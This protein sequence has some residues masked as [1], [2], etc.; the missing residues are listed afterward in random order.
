VAAGGASVVVSTIAGKRFSIPSI[1]H[2]KIPIQE[3]NV[4]EGILSLKER[5]P[6]CNA[7]G[8]KPSLSGRDYYLLAPQHM[9]FASFCMKLGFSGVCCLGCGACGLA[10]GAARLLF[11]ARFG[12]LCWN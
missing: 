10:A 12:W 6:G 8:T 4:A 11:A 9:T 1:N 3:E 7:K 2:Y 5:T